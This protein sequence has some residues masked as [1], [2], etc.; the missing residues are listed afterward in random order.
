MFHRGEVVGHQEAPGVEWETLT[1]ITGWCDWPVRRLVFG[2]EPGRTGP[3][4]ERVNPPGV[5]AVLRRQSDGQRFLLDAETLELREQREGGL[6]HFDSREPELVR[7]QLE[8]AAGRGGVSL[9]RRAISRD[10]RT[11]REP[12]PGD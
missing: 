6:E 8:D 2:G 7:S 9:A 4:Y 5:L 12:E 1:V 11:L 10:G 3:R